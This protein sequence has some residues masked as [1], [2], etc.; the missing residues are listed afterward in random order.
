MILQQLVI[1]ILLIAPAMKWWFK[2]IKET[3][4]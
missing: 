4:G 1:G 3:D 2:I